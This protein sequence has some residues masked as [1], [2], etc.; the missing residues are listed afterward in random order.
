[1]ARRGQRSGTAGGSGGDGLGVRR[2]VLGSTGV[3]Y[4]IFNT[5]SK[6]KKRFI[7]TFLWGD[8][9]WMLRAGGLLL[10]AQTK[11]PSE[12]FSSTAAS[13]EAARAAR[14]KGRQLFPAPFAV[15]P[16]YLGRASVAAGS[17]AA[18]CAG[19]WSGRCLVW[20]EAGFVCGAAGQF[21]AAHLINFPS[22]G[23]PRTRRLPGLPA[24][25]NIFIT[26]CYFRA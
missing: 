3:G 10:T 1:M 16:S 23:A 22:L 17:P 19:A 18:P 8:R 4:G 6:K 9:A 5:F 26:R 24:R 2:G 25:P 14:V 20:K 21:S 12:P 15:S 11:H 7:C 13:P